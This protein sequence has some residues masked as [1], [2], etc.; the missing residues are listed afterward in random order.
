MERRWPGGKEAKTSIEENSLGGERI[1]SFLITNVDIKVTK[2]FKCFESLA[3]GG[4]NF[5][6]RKCDILADEIEET[7]RKYREN[8]S[9]DEDSIPVIRVFGSSSTGQSTCVHVHGVLPYLYFRPVD[10]QDP[11]FQSRDLIERNKETMIERIEEALRKQISGRGQG[12]A[13]PAICK[14]EIVRKKSLY[15]Y[16]EGM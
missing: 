11:M 14:S 16:F 9:E 2:G 5:K 12:I 15:G 7:E 13:P 10:M 4:V 6:S 3:A 8:E 1:M